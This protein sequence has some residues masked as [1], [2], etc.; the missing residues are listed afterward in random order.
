MSPDDM[1]IFFLQVAVML[2]TALLFGQLMRKL[3]FPAV[4]GEL[5]GGIILGPDGTGDG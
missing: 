2:F 5:I 3:H 4:I 1:V